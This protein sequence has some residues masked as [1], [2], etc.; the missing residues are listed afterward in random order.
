MLEVNP[1]KRPSALKLL[2]HP[3]F[4]EVKTDLNKKSP[5]KKD[6]IEKREIENEPYMLKRKLKTKVLSTNTLNKIF[7]SKFP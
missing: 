3:F 4:H 5:E 6:A 1:R 7:A 2:S